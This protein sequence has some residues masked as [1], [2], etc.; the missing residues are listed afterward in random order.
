MKIS[1]RFMLSAASAAATVA[2][3]ATPA[4]PAATTAACRRVQIRAH[5]R[6]GLEPQLS[7]G[8]DRLAGLQPLV[9]HDVVVHALR[10]RD[11]P[12]FDGRIRLDDEHVLAVLTG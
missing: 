7:F 10:G 8:H 1:A 12:L 9:D 5:A 6:A 4:A 2:A 11:R 3:A